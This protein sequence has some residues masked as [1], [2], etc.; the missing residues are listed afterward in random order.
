MKA[1]LVKLD[2]KAA[3]EFKVILECLGK[4][5]NLDYLENQVIKEIVVFRESLAVLDNL[6]R[7]AL[8]GRWEYQVL[9]V[10]RVK[11]EIRVFQ[12]ILG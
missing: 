11:K 7:K 9:L 4:M 2:R 12:D 6:D 8:Q 10:Q 1:P 5:E 3:R